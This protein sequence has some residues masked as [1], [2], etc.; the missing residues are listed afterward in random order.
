MGLANRRKCTE[1]EL[2]EALETSRSIA[3]ALRKV[4]LAPAGGNYQTVHRVIE[5]LDIDT[6]HMIGQGWNIG[7]TAGLL[8]RDTIP[9]EEILVE[10]STYRGG[11][12][13]LKSRLVDSELK[14]YI[15][16]K[17]YRDTWNKKPIPLELEH[18]N[19][20]RTDN[21][22]VNLKLLCPNCHAQ[23][24]TYRGKNIGNRR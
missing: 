10:N 9:L 13:F 16:E 23:T 1:E 18:V 12:S 22:I 4:G 2:K 14:R 11:S 5:D 21:R 3:E 7:D 15:C 17:C 19:G 20:V 8:K 24:P 6:S